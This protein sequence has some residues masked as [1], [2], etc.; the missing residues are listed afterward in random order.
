MYNNR[1][2]NFIINVVFYVT[3]AAIAYL[4]SKFLLIYLFPFLIGLFVTVAV[5]CPANYVSGKINLKKGYC[6]LILVVL[7]YLLLIAVISAVLYFLGHYL[8]NVLTTENGVLNNLSE[9]IDSFYKLS[10]NFI[11]KLPSA[12]QNLIPA[13]SDK[14][15]N[16][17]TS[18]ISEIAKRA[19]SAA[20]M[21]ITSSIV[22][23]IASC[24]IAKDFDRFK[25]SVN[26]VL[27]ENYK[28][29]VAEIKS[30]F[31]EK[32]IKL[33][34]GYGKLLGITF[35]E[36][37]IGLLLLRIENA[38]IISAVI[39]LLDLLPIFGT[40]TILIPWA[41]LNFVS[42]EYYLG[43]GLVILYVIIVIIRNV[44]EPRIIGKQIGL[45]PLIALIC[46]FLGLKIFGFIGM[47]LVPVFVMLCY[48][49]F[50]R[51]IFKII[52][53]RDA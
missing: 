50:E 49:M 15:V 44:L 52:L 4:F 40:G 46:V 53:S 2:L 33:F 27:P 38:I 29:A 48:E 39:S 12:I 5:Q 8:S 35:A 30:L 23:I 36:L 20:P 11:N 18:Y 32:I 43:A 10:K 13:S 6:A 22:T 34:W 17:F 51:G 42:G 41:L 16:T 26:S 21:I 7:S 3:V 31:E 14:I 9:Q 45:H 47:I 19:A 37:L 1:K 28:V 24:Y 25:D